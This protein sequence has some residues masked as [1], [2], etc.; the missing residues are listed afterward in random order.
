MRILV[1][2]VAGMLGSTLFRVLSE[3]SEHDVYGTLRHSDVV[4]NQYDKKL[5]K[6]IDVLDN[7]LVESVIKRLKPDVV[8]NCVGVIKQLNFAE[9]PLVV[10]PINSLLPHRL[11][12]ICNSLDARLIH[13]STDCVFSGSL[14]NYRES[15][16]PDPLDLYG[17][18]KLLGEV[19]KPNALTIRTSIIGHEM[20]TKL[21]LL[22]WFLSKDSDVK[23]YASAFFSGL[24]TLELSKLIMN[25]ILLRPDISG[26]YHVAS[27]KISKYD[28]LKTVASVYG[29]NN[30]II[31]DNSILIDRSLNAKAFNKIAGYSP[32]IW[33]ELIEDMYEFNSK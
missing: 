28:L 10:I 16:N 21:A 32:P 26:L 1:L 17:R 30:N 27:H 19:N 23:G 31:E 29:K 3:S 13:I 6:G 7:H 14:G 20:N 4:F 24:T 33:R 22:E 12:K 15:D 25:K 5:L 18:S 2:G 8:I 11:Y 9:D